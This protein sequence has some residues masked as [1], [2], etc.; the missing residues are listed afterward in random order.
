MLLCFLFANAPSTYSLSESGREAYKN[1]LN[2][3]FSTKQ[4]QDWLKGLYERSPSLV[5]RSFPAGNPKNDQGPSTSKRAKLHTDSTDIS[6]DSSPS[7][8][9]SDSQHSAYSNIGRQLA[10]EHNLSNIGSDS[11]S[12]SFVCRNTIGSF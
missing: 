4:M 10:R 6:D 1:E 12:S 7:S 8:T 2:R 5:T 3:D 11:S 9:N